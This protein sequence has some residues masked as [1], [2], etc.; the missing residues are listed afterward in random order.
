MEKNLPTVTVFMAAYNAAPYITKAIQSI[1]NQTFRDFEL[2]IVD[3]GSTDNT[4]DVVNSFHDPRIR[5]IKNESNKGLGFTRNVA[6][7]EAEGEFL[8]ILDS[9]DIASANRLE[10]QVRHF[11]TNPKLAVL[12]SCAHIIDKNGNRTG[13]NIE[14]SNHSDQLCA[15]LFFSNTFVHSSI[16]MRTSV[17]REVGGYPNYPVAQD[18][19][20]F[21]RIGLKYEVGNLPE[22]LVD[23][24]M[25]DTNISLRKKIVVEQVLQDIL[26]YQLN[27][28]LPRIPPISTNILL[29]PVMGSKYTT[30]E[31]YT[32]YREIII[33]NRKKRLYPKRELEQ[34]LFENWYAIVIEKGKAKTFPLF[35]KGPIF[36]WKYATG[37]QLRRT[38]K[39]SIKHLLKLAK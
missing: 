38:F 1:L 36:N 30:N 19:A 27:L 21:A 14:L 12:G 15:T 11:S 6:L 17:F 35:L 9:D 26:L 10:K 22:Y 29:D 32:F 2:L 3:D 28:L 5:L 4:V 18:Y 7:K 33:Q 39:K 34:I 31:Y 24:R 23:Y 37:K 16:M 20:L 8:A 13:K 25:H